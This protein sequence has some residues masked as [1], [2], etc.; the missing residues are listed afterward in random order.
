MREDFIVVHLQEPC[1]YCREYMSGGVRCAPGAAVAGLCGLLWSAGRWNGRGR[2]GLPRQEGRALRAPRHG[3][4]TDSLLATPALPSPPSC[5]AATTTP[6]RPR[7][8]SSA[9]SAPLTAS[10]WTSR[11]ATPRARVRARPGGCCGQHGG[12]VP[13]ACKGAEGSARRRLLPCC[14]CAST[15]HHSP[16]QPPLVPPLRSHLHALCALRP[17]LLAGDC[18]AGAG[19]A[20]RHGPGG[21]AARAQPGAAFCGLF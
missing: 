8:L 2:R 11:G 19:A 15:S 7:R 3:L 20:P 14:C 12:T 10:A 4:P 5:P 1:S 21:A 6:P 16:T 17:L 13:A 18:G 9:P